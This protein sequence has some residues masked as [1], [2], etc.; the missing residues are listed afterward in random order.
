[1][2]K[3]FKIFAV[4][5]FIIV[6]FL[7]NFSGCR[8]GNG[9]AVQRE[10]LFTLGFGRLEDE[11]DLFDMQ[12]NRS[13]R[14][15]S[16]AMRD[17]LIY[18]A[19]GNGQKVC[20]YTSY[21]DILFMVYNDESNPAP[22]TLALGNPGKE[23]GDSVVTKWAN[24]YPLEEPGLIA[25]DSRKH[26]YVEDRIPYEMHYYD[27]KAGAYLDST[28]LHFDD[29]GNFVEY[30]G[31]EGPGGTAFPRIQGLYT[32]VQ[33]ELAVVCRIASGWNIH[34]FRPDG[35]LAYYR[36]IANEAIP[37][38]SEGL[39]AEIDNIVAAPDSRALY[40]KVDYFRMTYDESTQTL[41][42][43]AADSSKIWIMNM[44]RGEYTESF[45]APLF[46]EN[47][48]YTLLGATAE[49]KIFMNFP[50]DTGY[51]IVILDISDSANVQQRISTIEVKPDELQYNTF[52]ISNEGIMTGLLAGSDDAK[53]V[54]WRTDRIVNEMDE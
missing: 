40:I 29:E 9:A 37:G 5:S 49:G 6:I 14:R 20:R 50:I 25:I 1:M 18:I 15:T 22:L 39:F 32:S 10:N 54:W 42:G 44:E 12:G 4:L 17:G 11:I 31:R 24:S 13:D 21:G 46:D 52:A 53:I 51:Q 23:A 7:L 47:L 34:W 8:R 48:F 19:N 3:L 36:H 26:F 41:S 45:E 43:S 30:L 33:D 16:I 2:K 28:V 27:E 38:A 35:S